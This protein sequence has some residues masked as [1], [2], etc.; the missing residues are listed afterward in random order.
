MNNVLIVEDMDNHFLPAQRF[1]QDLCTRSGFAVD[2][3]QCKFGD[4]IDHFL[5]KCKSD[6]EHVVLIFDNGMERPGRGA[7]SMEDTIDALWNAVPGS[8]ESTIPIIIWAAK[9][10]VFD[11]LRRTPRPNSSIVCKLPPAG[12]HHLEELG[13]ALD[14]AIRVFH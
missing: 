13:S 4:G 14:R 12:K 9:I 8:W 10:D 2:V 5:E 7:Y 6:S 1:V 11:R 3:S